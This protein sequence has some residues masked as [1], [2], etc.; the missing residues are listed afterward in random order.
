MD[1]LWHRL[2]PSVVV[3]L[4]LLTA[5]LTVRAGTPEFPLLVVLDDR[6]SVAPVVL[7]QAQNEAFR[8]LWH[9]GIRI[10]WVPASTSSGGSVNAE[11]LAADRRTFAGRLIVQPRLPKNSSAQSRFLMGATPASAR[12]CSGESY[13]FFDQIAEFAEA[14]R[15]DYGVVMGTVV[16]HEIGHLLLRDGAHAAEGLMRTPW[17]LA[18][19]RRATLGL[20]LF[21]PSEATTMQTTIASC[22]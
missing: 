21:S 14:R 4:G 10:S 12:R 19:W 18:D 13:V 3:T 9:E 11:D 5:S 17:T 8:I 2:A 7:D 6:A 22:R 15:A 16:A 20:L 1:H